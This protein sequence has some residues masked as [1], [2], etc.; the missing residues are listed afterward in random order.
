[1]CLHRFM[2]FIEKHGSSWMKGFPCLKKCLFLVSIGRKQGNAF[3]QNIS[4]EQKILHSIN[5]TYQFLRLIANLIYVKKLHLISCD[6]DCTSFWKKYKKCTLISTS[7]LCP[8]TFSVGF[9]WLYL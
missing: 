6:F 3:S 1:M 2:C 7:N 5:D 8:S 9:F 4:C